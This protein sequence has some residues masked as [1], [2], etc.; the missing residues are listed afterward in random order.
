MSAARAGRYD[1]AT[2]GSPAKFTYCIA[3][4]ERRRRGA[5]GHRRHGAVYGGEPPHN[6][7]DHVSTT[8]SGILTTLCDTPSSLG[9]NVAVFLRRVSLPRRPGPEHAK[10]GL[11]TT[12]SRAPTCRLRLRARAS[13]RS[14]T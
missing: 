3:E 2:Q 1:M 9:S 8:A 5:D 11:P 7:N 14:D 4:N 12:A 6:V 10:D 13:V